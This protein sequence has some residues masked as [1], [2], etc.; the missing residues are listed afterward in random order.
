MVREISSAR[1]SK[2]W[3]GVMR[4]VTSRVWGVARSSSGT[5][6]RVL[7]RSRRISMVSGMGGVGTSNI[8]RLTLN[9]EVED[10]EREEA[11]FEGFVEQES[12]GLVELEGEGV[13]GGEPA[14]FLGFVVQGDGGAGG[15]GYVVE[16]Q[17]ML[18]AHELGRVD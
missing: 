11:F 1:P 14:E 8:E 10:S 12:S 5:P 9:I 17:E 4:T 6:M 18:G 15:A 16:E 2:P 13:G 7:T 3:E